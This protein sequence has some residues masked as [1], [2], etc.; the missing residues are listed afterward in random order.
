M[1]APMDHNRLLKKIAN[2]KF[3]PIGIIQDG[4]SRVFLFDKGWY[5]IVIEFQPSS[6]SK[7][8]YLNI[9]VDF[10]FYPRDYFT[11]TCGY[12][13]S[14]FEEF[15]NEQEFTKRIE[16]LCDLSIER[17]RQLEIKFKDLKAGISTLNNE[18]E[19]DAWR[20]YDLAVFYALE[21]NLN[22]ALR[23]FKKVSRV[24]C[25][26]DFEYERKKITDDHIKLLRER[27]SFYENVK[28]INA[29]TRQLK[30]LS[31]FDFD[32][33]FLGRADENDRG[34]KRW[35]KKILDI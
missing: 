20:Y 26:Y 23:L 28:S 6:F 30:N 9:G 12:R 35:W 14:G 22:K 16:E 19:K 34:L 8:T 5:T 11:F 10:H 13:E 31:F 27:P 1:K 33:F 29:K 7:G 15:E 25:E 17:V 32:T 24:K 21:G 3:K 2:E 18:R 4:N